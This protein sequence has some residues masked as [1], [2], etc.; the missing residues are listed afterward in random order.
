MAKEEEKA[1]EM[2]SRDLDL[3]SR[4]LDLESR[5]I[6]GGYFGPGHNA[7]QFGPPGGQRPLNLQMQILQR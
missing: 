5:A 7:G 4:E 1:I 3:E 2:E 6:P